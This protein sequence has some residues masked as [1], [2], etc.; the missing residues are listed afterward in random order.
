MSHSSNILT[1]IIVESFDPVASD[2]SFGNVVKNLQIKER[3]YATG[4]KSTKSF[5]FFLD[6]G[7]VFYQEVSLDR[8]KHREYLKI[9]QKIL[10][11]E[12]KADFLIMLCPLYY[13]DLTFFK[14]KCCMNM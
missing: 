10:S 13:Q 14:F 8:S 5:L 2:L 4:F 6:L 7:Y 3:I 12:K 9:L 11:G 1:L